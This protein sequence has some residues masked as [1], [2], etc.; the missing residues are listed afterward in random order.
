MKNLLFLSALF[1]LVVYG[2]KLDDSLISPSSSKQ[3]GQI[4]LKFDKT[5]IPSGITQV[6]AILSRSGF[7]NIT[8][9]LN[10]L[11]DSTA[12]ISFQNLTVGIWHLL[13]QAKDSLNVVRFVGETDIN[14]LENQI[15]QVNLTLVPATTGAGGIHIVVN[16]GGVPESSWIDFNLN[17][18]VK[19]AISNPL[20]VRGLSHSKILFDNNIY[21]MWFTAVSSDGKGYV[22]YA[23]SPDGINW[24]RTLNTPVLSPSSGNKWDN[25]IVSAGAVLKEGGTYKMFYS[26]FSDS[27]GR[28]QIGFATSLDGINWV[29][30]PNPILT[31]QA[32]WEYNVGVTEVIKVNNVYY[33][34]YHGHNSTSNYQISIGL[35]TS[36]DGIQ[37]VKHSGN[38]VLTK[39]QAWEGNGVLAPS[40]IREDSM[41]IMAYGNAY[42][43]VSGFGLATSLDGKNW[44]KRNDNPFFTRAKTFNNWA[45]Q[46][47]NF[48]NLRSFGNELRIYY[49]G[50]F[51]GTSAIGMVKKIE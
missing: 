15:T 47:I 51:A 34:Y 24:S 4:L 10:I 18:I 2:C 43:Y 19:P 8:G 21:K 44:I 36:I 39:T 20:E 35:A 13:V 14:I 40:I 41:F 28:Y 7:N 45:S 22:F 31:G 12:E 3:S 29:K 38:P 16:W 42:S 25:K 48:P 9:N 17:P 49:S 27:I 1:L 5:S 11:S 30:N 46:E 23:T 33:L 32:L 26:G 6:T 37:W 50:F